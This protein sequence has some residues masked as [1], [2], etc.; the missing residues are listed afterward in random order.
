MTLRSIVQLRVAN[1]LTTKP[2]S[3]S[4]F[5]V[6][7]FCS[8][9]PSSQRDVSMVVT[10]S[11]PHLLLDHSSTTPQL[12]D[13]IVDPPVPIT[14]ATQRQKGIPA[15]SNFVSGLRMVVS[16][17]ASAVSNCFSA[18]QEVVTSN[19]NARFSS[20][21]ANAVITPV[22][23]HNQLH[24]VS[25]EILI[26]PE[27][28]NTHAPPLHSHVCPVTENAFLNDANFIRGGGNKF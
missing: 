4:M 11:T 17:A 7:P 26:S 5:N 21:A 1:A 27:D 8:I 10:N 12:T 6:V 2:P 15:V 28:T 24:Y 9:V 14:N 18:P 23:T 20:T 19:L 25:E 16:S 13:A 22:T 3:L